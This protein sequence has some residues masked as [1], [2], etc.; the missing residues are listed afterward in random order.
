MKNLKF[1]TKIFISFAIISIFVIT[2]LLTIV[3]TIDTLKT[4]S[5]ETYSVNKRVTLFEELKNSVSGS[6]INVRD[7]RIMKD[8]YAINNR[9]QWVKESIGN[10]K[11]TANDLQSGSVATSD[12]AVLFQLNNKSNEYFSHINNILSLKQ[13]DL[14]K[15]SDDEMTSLSMLERELFNSLDKAIKDATSKNDMLIAEAG[16]FS[17]SAIIKVIILMVIALIIIIFFGIILNSNLSKPLKVVIDK[18][19]IVSNG[20]FTT[21]VSMKFLKRKDE[22]GELA[23]AVQYMEKSL[24]DHIKEILSCSKDLDNSSQQLSIAVGEMTYKFEFIDNSTKEIVIGTQDT[25][26]SAEE[27]TASVEEFNSNIFELSAKATDGSNSANESKKR[28]ILVQ[29]EG[30]NAVKTTDELY[31]EREVHIIKAIEEGK[32]VDEIK[33]MA[34]TIADLAEQTNLLALNASIEAARAGEH[35]RGFAVVANEVRNLAEQ[36]Q[37]AVKHIKYTALKVQQA[38]K[39]LSSNSKEVLNFMDSHVKNQFHSFIEKGNQ[40]YNDADY[41]SK[42]SQ[43]IAYMSEEISSTISQVSEAVQ[44]MA[45]I[46]QDSAESSNKILKNIDDVKQE[47]GQVSVTAQDQTKLARRLNELVYKFK[48]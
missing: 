16:E 48:I 6:G 3:S 45:S 11:K 5:N 29:E 44:N 36:S 27:I 18:L 20:D 46:S 25:S 21:T 47:I 23:R 43:D 31:K 28:A 14:S 9:V 37:N 10:Y 17:N 38:F 32:I 35:G 12:K 8:T 13:E 22:I 40:Y 33:V 24:S 30:N 4:I 1:R 7:L 34:D 15:I 2:L 19:N 41:V 26:A 42:M 39:N